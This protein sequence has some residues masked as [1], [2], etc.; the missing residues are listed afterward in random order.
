MHKKQ[1]F[2][3]LFQVPSI[4]TYGTF[5]GIKCIQK[6]YETFVTLLE[7]IVVVEKRA[8]VPPFCCNNGEHFWSKS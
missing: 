1:Q 7:R 8:W 3:L 5:S 4:D 6:G 2:F